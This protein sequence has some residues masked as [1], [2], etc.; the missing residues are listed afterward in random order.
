MN[1]LIIEDEALLAE[2]L[3][4]EIQ[5][6]DSNMKVI[7]ILPSIQD[8]LDYFETHPSPDLIFSDIELSDGLSFEIF[9]QIKHHPPVIFCT[10]YNHYA[11]EAFRARGID[12]ILKPFETEDIRQAIERYQATQQR[13]T[14]DFQALQSF[15]TK[16]KNTEQRVLVH[17]GETIIPVNT[18]EIALAELKYGTVFIITFDNQ[19]YSINDSIEKLTSQLG[20]QFYRANRQHLIQRKAVLQVAHYFGRKLVVKPTINYQEQILVSKAKANHFLRWLEGSS[21]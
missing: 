19:R 5:S 12:Y 9:Q 16:E 4:G 18:T 1:V 20:D 8:T 21:E 17:R 15:I 11:V 13:S 10:A 2:A 3:A 7:A 6:V 14:I